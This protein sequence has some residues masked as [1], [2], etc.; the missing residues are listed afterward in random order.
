MSGDRLLDASP[1]VVKQCCAAA[2]GSDW[3]SMLLG[4]SFHPGGTRLTDRLAELLDLRPG[5]TVLD[6]AAGRGTSALHLASTRHCDVVGI[7]LSVT[8]VAAA[9]AAAAERGLDDRVR[10]LVGDA[11]RLP[12]DTARVDAVLCECAFCTFPDKSMAAAE[13]RRVLKPGGVLGFSDLVRRGALPADLQDLLA[14]V[15]CVADALPVEGYVEHLTTAGIE[16]DHV[17]GHDGALADMA[18][19]VRSR[20]LMGRVLSAARRVDLPGVDW[21][22]ASG[23]ARTAL[24]AIRDGVLGYVILRG[25][26]SSV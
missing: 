13:F 1:P 6:V 10:F 7:D 14:W 16:V 11:E 23:V 3:A 5:M 15:A 17:E 2:Y 19:Q 9:T 21:E 22:R 24:T 12:V 26:T 8:N 4:D 18:E 20:L 25:R